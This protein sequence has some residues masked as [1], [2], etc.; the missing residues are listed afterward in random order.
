MVVARIVPWSFA[1]D[2]PQCWH[3][4]QIP[5]CQGGFGQTDGHDALPHDCVPHEV[6]M[7]RIS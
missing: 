1:S 4:G 7:S 5:L 6:V 2:V 3:V